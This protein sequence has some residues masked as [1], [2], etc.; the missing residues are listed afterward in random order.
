MFHVDVQFLNVISNDT[1]LVY[2]WTHDQTSR[3]NNKYT[4]DFKQLLFYENKYSWAMAAAQCKEYGMILP[5]FQNEK[6]T[7]EFV[8]FILNEYMLP[9]YALFIGL[10]KKVGSIKYC[11]ICNLIQCYTFP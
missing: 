7:R 6:S 1:K 4:N 3:G 2:Q 11:I 8:S 10:V 5:H 9:T